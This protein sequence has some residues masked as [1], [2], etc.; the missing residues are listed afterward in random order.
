MQFIS[1]WPPRKTPESKLHVLF[2]S[3]L[4]FGDSRVVLFAWFRVKLEFTE[5][6]LATNK[7]IARTYQSECAKHN[8]ELHKDLALKARLIEDALKAMPPKL[9]EHAVI[10]DETIPPT[11]RPWARYDTPPIKGFNPL[12]Y[13]DK[14]KK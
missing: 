10:I 8:A 7:Q 2:F 14:K 9:R 4:C 6:E 12:D 13:I 11:D 5:E 3:V 1:F